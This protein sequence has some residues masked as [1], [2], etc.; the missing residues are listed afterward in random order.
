[1][2]FALMMRVE[3]IFL[4]QIQLYREPSPLGERVGA[5]GM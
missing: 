5:R 1:M 3:D 2:S 4:M